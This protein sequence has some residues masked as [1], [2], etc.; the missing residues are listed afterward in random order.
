VGSRNP[1]HYGHPRTPLGGDAGSD[2]Y[3]LHALI[4]GANLQHIAIRGQ[5]LIDGSGDAFRWKGGGRPKGV[6][7]QNCRDVLVENVNMRNAG[8]WM[9]HYRGCDRIAIR[10]ITVFN[11]A[12]YNND[13][14]NIDSCRDVRISDCSVDSDDDAVVLKSLSDRPCRNV[15]IANCT[16]SSH[17][18]SIKM[19]TESGGGFQNIA[20]T[21]CTI[22][23]PRH[24]QAIYGRQR[25]LAG[26]ALEIVDG[27][28]MDGVL[29]S[30][31]SVKGVSVPIFMRLGNRARQYVKGAPMPGV[32]TFRNV[33]IS[34]IIADDASEIGCSIT[35]LPGHPIEN[36][37]LSNLKLGFDGGGRKELSSQEVPEKPESYPESTMFGTLPA[38]GFYC[39][40][41]DGLTFCNVQLR[42][43]EPDLR[44]ALVCDDVANLM[45]DGL[46]AAWWEGASAMVRLTQARGALIRGCRP[47][48]RVDTFLRL[49]GDASQRVLLTGNDFSLVATI[50]E[51]AAD[52]PRN[53]LMQLGNHPSEAAKRT[54][55]KKDTGAAP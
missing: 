46:H 39:R 55:S 12:T 8:S 25:G 45:I 20:I 32:G 54:H 26:I 21:N 44:H 52:A 47:R 43:A 53:A 49:E 42:T 33:V 41:V 3:S 17:C 50:A 14:L 11:H 15:V 37:S 22:R 36:V 2:S 7:L 31:V 13:G 38:Y 4:A 34:N 35:G 40:H 19:G 28:R 16:I 30:N 27:G 48:S 29:I 9:Q 5:G 6:Y 1:E 51:S 24:S 10:G 18:N 23:S